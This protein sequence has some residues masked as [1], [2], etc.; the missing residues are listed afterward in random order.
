M[1][2]K[3]AAIATPASPLGG[4]RGCRASQDPLAPAHR[5]CGPG[6]APGGHD[7][8]AGRQGGIEGVARERDETPAN[9]RRRH[10]DAEDGGASAH[11]RGARPLLGRVPRV[12][13]RRMARRRRR[14]RVDRV[15]ADAAGEEGVAHGGVPT[16]WSRS[17]VVCQAP[18]GR[19]ADRLGRPTAQPPARRGSRWS[20]SRATAWRTTARSTSPSAVASRSGGPEGLVG[21]DPPPGPSTAARSDS[22]T[23]RRTDAARTASTTSGSRPS[24][25][26]STSCPMMVAGGPSANSTWGRART[27]AAA[28]SRASGWPWAKPLARR[29]ATPPRPR[30]AQR[31]P[32]PRRARQ[33]HV[34]HQALP[35]GTRQPRRPG[36][37]APGDDR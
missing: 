3:S 31:P 35:A 2:R 36:R 9:P 14:P 34:T 28:S 13:I 33:R 12:A 23:R 17:A 5:A 4:P 27:A 10:R 19:P 22:S 29:A 37:L 21:G 6:V 15:V 24:M 18:H 32:S 16:R 8:V 7:R 26:T 30:T 1:S 20:S 11:Q 25:K